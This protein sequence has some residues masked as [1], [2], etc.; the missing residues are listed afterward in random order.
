MDM[1]IINKIKFEFILLIFTCFNISLKNNIK[2]IKNC[3]NKFKSYFSDYF[4]ININNFL[5]YLFYN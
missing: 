2:E 1:E 4:H 5:L 3:K